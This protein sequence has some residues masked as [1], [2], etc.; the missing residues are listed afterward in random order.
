RRGREG[1]LRA[2]LEL[3]ALQLLRED[4]ADHG[5]A[6]SQLADLDPDQQ[7]AVLL[8][9]MWFQLHRELLRNPPGQGRGSTSPRQ[10]RR[11]FAAEVGPL[12]TRLNC[13]RE[14]WIL[15]RFFESRPNHGLMPIAYL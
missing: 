8:M 5:E 14:F 1:D 9:W 12:G 15:L 10:P 6:R 13:D 7:A 3:R 11:P 4:I 2:A